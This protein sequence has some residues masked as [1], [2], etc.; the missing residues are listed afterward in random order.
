MPQM[1]SPDDKVDDHPVLVEQCPGVKCGYLC[2]LSLWIFALSRNPVGDRWHARWRSM[3][4]PSGIHWW[5][6]TRALASHGSVPCRSRDNCGLHADTLVV[7]INAFELKEDEIDITPWLPRLCDGFA[8]NFTIRVSGLKD[9]GD[10]RAV[11]SEVTGDFWLITGKIFI[12]LDEVGHITT[13]NGMNTANTAPVLNVSSTIKRNANGTTESLSYIVI[14]ERDLSFHSTINHSYGEV[15]SNW[16]QTLSFTNEGS[17]SDGAN[18]QSNLQRTRGL[19]ISSN[20][21]MK[22]FAYSLQVDSVTSLVQDHII[23]YV[24]R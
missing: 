4:I 10:G 9:D 12:W 7:G 3:A 16:Q 20:G 23:A 1:P 15:V 8:H 18:V 5:H 13:G 22:N 2:R 11:L 17:L 24:A 19:D 14:A 6:C 21:Y